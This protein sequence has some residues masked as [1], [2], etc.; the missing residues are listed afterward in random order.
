MASPA[1]MC[2]R[3]LLILLLTTTA[4]LAQ[5][6][7]VLRSCQELFIAGYV[8]DAEYM[9]DPD[10]PGKGLPAIPVYCDM[11]HEDYPG[12]TLIYHDQMFHGVVPNGFED[13]GEFRIPVTYEGGASIQ[14]ISNVA[15]ISRNCSQYLRV[16]C[17]HI[18]M[19]W[20]DDPWGYWVSRDGSMMPNWGSPTGTRGCECSLDQSCDDPEHQTCNCDANDEEWRKDDGDVTDKATLPVTEL[21]FGDTGSDKEKVVYKVGPLKCWGIEQALFA[22]CDEVT[23][24]GYIGEGDYL[25]LVPGERP[26]VQRCNEL[27]LTYPPPVLRSCEELRLAGYTLNGEYLIDPDYSGTGLMPFPVY[28]DMTTG[29]TIIS[30]DQQGPLLSKGFNDKGEHHIIVHYNGASLQQ[31]IGLVDASQNCEQSISAQ[32]HDSHI[33]SGHRTR[34]VY[35]WWIS[36]NGTKMT[37]WGTPTGVEGCPCSLTGSCED[38]RDLCN[39]DANDDVWRTDGGI[40]NDKDTLPVSQ[41]RVGDTGGSDEVA[42]YS[43]GE[44]KCTGLGNMYTSCT[45]LEGDGISGGGQYLIDADGEGGQDPTVVM[46]EGSTAQYIGQTAEQG[47]GVSSAALNFIIFGV[48]LLLLI[49]IIVLVIVV[50]QW[51]RVKK[52]QHFAL[53][54]PESPVEST[55]TDQKS[56]ESV[57]HFSSLQFYNNRDEPAKVGNEYQ[58]TPLI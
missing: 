3:K 39:C 57:D 16:D 29:T 56:I 43:L 46:C 12:T 32:C 15:D 14:Q 47:T 35:T 40:L 38:R 21:R 23:A 1:M 9:I 26:Q 51:Q 13:A 25:I 45:A 50:L 53:T 19:W 28:C 42:L 58:Q 52:M 34:N 44:L 5:N 41:L 37:N 33:F 55:N 6:T 27:F 20:K 18:T 7:P 30:H 8:V 24:A 22:S 17:H 36:R 54:S 11:A 4:A 10:G 49:V 2:C 48:I 31:A